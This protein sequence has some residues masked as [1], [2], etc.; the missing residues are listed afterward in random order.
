MNDI[1]N[2]YGRKSPDQTQDLLV[3]NLVIADGH[4]NLFYNIIHYWVQ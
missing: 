3:V 1:T 4:F 2:H